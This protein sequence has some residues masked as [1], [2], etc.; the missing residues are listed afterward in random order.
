MSSIT[1]GQRT[2]RIGILF[3]EEKNT[4]YRQIDT[5]IVANAE[6]NITIDHIKMATPRTDKDIAPA[7]KLRECPMPIKSTNKA[8]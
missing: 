1:R 2:T 3:F 5:I 7:R 8:T 6:R 4:G